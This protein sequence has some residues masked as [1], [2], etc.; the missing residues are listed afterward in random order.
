MHIYLANFITADDFECLED[1]ARDNARMSTMADAAEPVGDVYKSIDDLLDV[2][3]ATYLDQWVDMHDED[4]RDETPEQHNSHLFWRYTAGADGN[5]GTIY[6]VDQRDLTPDQLF[7]DDAGPI[8]AVSW[9]R[10]NL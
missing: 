8:M 7:K 9:R 4:E 3:R 6:L 10:I 2:A 5:T 1:E